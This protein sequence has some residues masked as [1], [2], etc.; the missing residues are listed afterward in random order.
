MVGTTNTNHDVIIE[1]AKKAYD[2]RNW[3]SIPNLLD[4]QYKLNR[5][6]EES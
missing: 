5:S 2:L 6:Y 3:D 4:E 1:E